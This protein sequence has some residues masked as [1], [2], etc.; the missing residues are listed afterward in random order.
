M[1]QGF[2]FAPVVEPIHDGAFLTQRMYD[3]VAAGGANSVPLM[4]GVMS[5][6]QIQRAEGSL[7]ILK[8]EK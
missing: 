7:N 4:M 2:Q 5:E 8:R 6:E 1:V 3:A